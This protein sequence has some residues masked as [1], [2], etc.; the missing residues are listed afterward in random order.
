MYSCAVDIIQTEKKGAV[1]VKSAMELK[2][3]SK[4]EESLLEQQIKAI[5]DTGAKVIVAGVILG[6]MDL[7]YMIKFVLMR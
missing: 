2:N 4:G 5:A 1:L 7:Y 6:G 3:F